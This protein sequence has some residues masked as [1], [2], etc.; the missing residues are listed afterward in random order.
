MPVH[1]SGQE[2]V[3]NIRR[4]GTT[5][6]EAVWHAFGT[7]PDR[8]APFQGSHPTTL[9]FDWGIPQ[10]MCGKWQPSHEKLATVAY[11]NFSQLSFS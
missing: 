10:Q 7:R 1:G 3:K 6:K 4:D 2:V 8:M 11:S 9:V 5:E